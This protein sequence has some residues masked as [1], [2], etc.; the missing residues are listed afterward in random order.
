MSEPKNDSIGNHGE[1]ILDR[2]RVVSFTVKSTE[3]TG[4]FVVNQVVGQ[5]VPRFLK[6]LKADYEG[7]EFRRRFEEG[8]V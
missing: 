7:V 2:A 5:V 1:R 6:Q 3:R 8:S 4:R